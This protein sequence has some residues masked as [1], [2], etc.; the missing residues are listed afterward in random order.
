MKSFVNDRRLGFFLIVI[1]G[2]CMFL[3]GCA[4]TINYSYDPAADFSMGK[5]YSWI[6]GLSA[7]R[8]DTLIDKNVRYYTD[9][10]LKDKGFALTSDKP[11]FVISTSYVLEYSS[12]PYK[13]KIL[14]L[15]VYRIPGKELIWQGTAGGTIK[16]DAA[17]PDLAGAVMKILVNF[18]PMR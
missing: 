1:F 18:P 16:A 4:A 11:D 6:P 17:S 14:N 12:D 5:N 15:Y 13:L 7:Y 10:S 8:Q 9:Q 2:V 3:G